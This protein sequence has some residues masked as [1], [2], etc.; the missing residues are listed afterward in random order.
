MALAAADL[1]QR[2]IELRETRGLSQEK[3]GELVGVSGQTWMRW[4]TGANR[5]NH[6]S[7][8]KIVETFGVEPS[9]LTGAPS[10]VPI[11]ERLEQKLDLL[12]EHFQ[13]PTEGLDEFAE[14][15]EQPLANGQPAPAQDPA[16]PARKPRATAS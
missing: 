15:L 8:Q 1:R 16:A 2:L 5:P 13:I 4:E 7:V 9:H 12:L 10:Y 14:A 3:A 6:E 11:W